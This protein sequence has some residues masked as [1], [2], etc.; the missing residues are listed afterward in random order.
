MRM[1]WEMHYCS[2]LLPDCIFINTILFVIS[3]LYN[4]H[5]DDTDDEYHKDEYTHSRNVVYV[6]KNAEKYMCKILMHK[7]V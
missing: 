1:S 7:R 6:V 2:K 5:F 4:V 3:M